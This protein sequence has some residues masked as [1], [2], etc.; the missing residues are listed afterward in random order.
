MIDSL[1][2]RSKNIG[3]QRI[4]RQLRHNNQTKEIQKETVAQSYIGII[5][6]S[7]I[8]MGEGP[9]DIL[10]ERVRGRFKRPQPLN[11]LGHNTIIG[12]A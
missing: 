1:V 3:Y 12:G 2:N 11:L 9:Q 8:L 4:G 6:P 7:P 5:F 10:A